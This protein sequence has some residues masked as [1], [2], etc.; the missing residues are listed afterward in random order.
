MNEKMST[1]FVVSARKYRPQT[2]DDVVGQMHITATLQNAVRTGKVAHAFLFCGPR[3]VGKTTCARILAKV[4]NCFN[5][6]DNIEP[7]NTCDSCKGFN[8]SHS[9]NIHELDAASNNG[10]DDMRQLI[11]QVRIAPQIGKYNIYIIDEVHMLT[12]Q[13][14]NAFLKTLEEP[15]RHALFIMATTEKHKVLPTILSRCQVFD[16]RRITVDD[17]ASHLGRIAVKEGIESDSEAL[18]AI[19][20]KSDGALRDALSIFDRIV[21]FSGQTFTYKDVIENLNIL[22]YDYYFRVIQFALEGNRAALLMLYHEVMNSGFDGG[23][24][25]AGLAEHIRNLLMVK[26]IQTAKFIDTGESARALYLTQSALL[27]FSALLAALEL[28]HGAENQYKSVQNKRLWVELTLMRLASRWSEMEGAV[29]E[30]ALE[31]AKKKITHPLALESKVEVSAPVP[32]SVLVEKPP[33][34]TQETKQVGME[35]EAPVLAEA[36]EN[37][38]V[39]GEVPNKGNYEVVRRTFSVHFKPTTQGAQPTLHRRNKPYSAD[40]LYVQWEKS[41]GLLPGLDDSLI[42]IALMRKPEILE[43]GSLVVGLEHKGMEPA[44]DEVKQQLKEILS[45]MLENDYITIVGKVKLHERTRM[46]FT[47]DEKYTHMAASYPVLPEL[48]TALKLSY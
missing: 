45:G 41:V 47:N 30:S 12:T 20:L 9:F 4:L 42:K 24:F 11:E 43:D 33:V 39:A 26:D 3:G 36:S 27:E 1:D 48:K 44:F 17:I 37:I 46:P 14:F 38:A 22:D 15:P 5:L 16:F 40:E 32:V 8:T 35:K 34:Q 21:T 13:A 18:H 28:V 19:A 29:S 31:A 25:L 10:V 6:T 7:C 2:F 23:V